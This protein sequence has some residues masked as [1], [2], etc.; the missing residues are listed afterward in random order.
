[1]AKVSLPGSRR[2]V[3]MAVNEA[4]ARHLMSRARS[5]LPVT[6]ASMGPQ[7][8]APDATFKDIHQDLSQKMADS[9][10][11]RDFEFSGRTLTVTS[12]TEEV[13]VMVDGED[14]TKDVVAVALST[15]PSAGSVA[16][17]GN[18]LHQ[19]PP[20][21]FSA[22]NPV[23][24]GTG[25]EPEVVE[26]L[27]S[28]GALPE[29][30][31]LTDSTKMSALGSTEPMLVVQDQPVVVTG[32][33]VIVQGSAP[34]E[35]PKE[36]LPVVTEDPVAVLTPQEPTPVVENKEKA[37]E[38]PLDP[39]PVVDVKPEVSKVSTK[40]EISRLTKVALVEL[41]VKHSVVLGE[42]DNRNQVLAK[43]LEVMFPS[44]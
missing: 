15:E 37:S 3:R 12:F 43:V 9:L 16:E 39:V 30:A 1:M 22:S 44:K 20:E 35:A 24:P 38:T 40:G 17:V 23:P 10:E 5:G 6:L 33:P 25:V 29:N 14:V 26:E 2:P 32:E 21:Q 42:E 11:N 19:M 31:E 27:T 8:P 13:K 34:A 7:Q 41:A 18:G 28:K 36:T 4:Q